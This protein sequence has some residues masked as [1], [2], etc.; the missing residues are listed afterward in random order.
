M[1]SHIYIRTRR[2]RDAAEVN[3]KAAAVDAAYIEKYNIQGPYRMM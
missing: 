1:P 2:Y 3:A